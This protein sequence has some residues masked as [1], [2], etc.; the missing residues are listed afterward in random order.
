MRLLEK[1]LDHIQGRL[2]ELDEKLTALEKRMERLEK[3][4]Y[5]LKKPEPRPWEVP[6]EEDEDA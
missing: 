6:V 3:K 5:W 4:V 1:F 2:M